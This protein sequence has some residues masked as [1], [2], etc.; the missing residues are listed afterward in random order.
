MGPV[1]PSIIQDMRVLQIQNTD[2]F[3]SSTSFPSTIPFPT[4][5]SWYNSVHAKELEYLGTVLHPNN[6]DG[7][8]ETV[9]NDDCSTRSI[10]AFCGANYYGSIANSWVSASH[11]SV[12]HSPSSNAAFPPGDGSVVASDH[13]Y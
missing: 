2:I 13:V 10:D 5:M 4:S 3:G 6:G 12:Y 11:N 8:N 1:D 7:C 9:V